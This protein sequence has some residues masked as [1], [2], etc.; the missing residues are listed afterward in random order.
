MDLTGLRGGEDPEGEVVIKIYC[1]KKI[2]F[3]LKKKK[4]TNGF[5]E[6]P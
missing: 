3:Q 1:M 5:L 2:N 4:K 6:H